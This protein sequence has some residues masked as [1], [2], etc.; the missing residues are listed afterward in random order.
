MINVLRFGNID[1]GDS[2]YKTGGSIRID[3]DVDSNIMPIKRW[4]NFIRNFRRFKY[5]SWR[6]RFIHC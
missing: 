5:L 3:K 6:S 1:I 2:T 4:K